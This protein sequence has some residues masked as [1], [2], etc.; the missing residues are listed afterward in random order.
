MEEE[1]VYE[2]F[3]MVIFEFVTKFKARVYDLLDFGFECMVKKLYVG[4]F[5]GDGCFGNF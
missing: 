1:E 4:M 3:G 5:L 2:Y